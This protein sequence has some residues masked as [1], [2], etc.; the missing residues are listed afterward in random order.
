[1]PLPRHDMSRVHR[2]PRDQRNKRRLYLHIK[3][4]GSECMLGRGQQNELTV[5]L[6]AAKNVVNI[7]W[8]EALRVEHRL[9]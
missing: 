5:F 6:D 1:M 7:V 4:C 3:E 2:I 8:E 9:D